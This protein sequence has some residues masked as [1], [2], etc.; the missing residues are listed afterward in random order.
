VHVGEVRAQATECEQ[1]VASALE[2]DWMSGEPQK[3]SEM[4][5]DVRGS[6]ANHSGCLDDG[7]TRGE[8]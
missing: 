3:S 4:T 8:H 5:R 1:E 6:G 7:S 2:P